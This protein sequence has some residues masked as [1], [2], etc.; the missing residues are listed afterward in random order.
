MMY[1][2]RYILII[3]E[4]RD[5]LNNIK[6]RLILPLLYKISKLI[7]YFLIKMINNY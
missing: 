4:K 1:N 3:L 5:I 6:E 2:N 7:N